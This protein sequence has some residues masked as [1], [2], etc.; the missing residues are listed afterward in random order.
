MCSALRA[1]GLWLCYATLQNLMPYFPWIAPP[2]P[3]PWRNPRKGRDQIL[4]S[5]NHALAASL[6]LFKGPLGM[7]LP[8]PSSFLS[9]S[10]L[11]K[12]GRSGLGVQTSPSSSFCPHPVIRCPVPVWATRASMLDLKIQVL[13]LLNHTAYRIYSPQIR[14]EKKLTIYQQRRC[15][16]S[17][18][19]S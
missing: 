19:D 8:P 13:V 14:P 2:R 17:G 4:P 10:M 1:S 6:L 15:F 5:G 9:P 7:G 16:P 18:F 3:P 11:V 12:A